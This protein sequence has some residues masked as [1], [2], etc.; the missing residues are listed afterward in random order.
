[1]VDVTSMSQPDILSSS[2]SSSSSFSKG[3]VQGNNFQNVCLMFG[4]VIVDLNLSVG[5]Q[6]ISLI[7]LLVANS[8]RLDGV[9]SLLDR[10]ANNRFR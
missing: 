10:F 7:A 5:C 1:M 2:F 4:Y 9:D 8:G 3:K 6:Q